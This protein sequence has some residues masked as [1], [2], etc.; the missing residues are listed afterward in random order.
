MS[1]MYLFRPCLRWL[2]YMGWWGNFY[3]QRQHPKAAR[4]DTIIPLP[5]RVSFLIA[6]A[7]EKDYFDWFKCRTLMKLPA[8]FRLHFWTTL[9]LQAS[10]GEPAILHAVLALSSVH[11]GVT[12]NGGRQEQ[13]NSASDK[14]EQLTL[15][16]YLKAIRHLQ[17]HFAARDR[18]SF[19]VALIAC[20][21]FISLDFLRGHFAAAQIHLQNGLKLLGELHSLSGENQ[22]LLILGSC[23]EGVDHWIVEEFSG[24]NIQVELFKY[25]HP[26]PSLLQQAVE[27]GRPSGTFSTFKKA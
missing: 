4:D 15:Q 26:H 14:V 1:L 24:L 11:R 18:A 22:E 16:P 3:G 20:I 9:L 10:L 2:W 12:L 6:N 27:P 5:A 13:N 8:S 17:P 25:F 19:R 21:V 7:A 23:S